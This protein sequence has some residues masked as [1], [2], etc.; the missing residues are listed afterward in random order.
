M[1][2][3]VRDQRH[4]K[5]RATQIFRWLHAVKADRRM[6]ASCVKVAMQLTHKTSE[7]E[8]AKSGTLVS[9]WQ[10][11]LTIAAAIGRG[12][13]T[14]RYAIRRL[15]SCGYVLT[16]HGHGEGQA[17]Q[18]TLILPN[19]QELAAYDGSNTGKVLPVSTDPKR[20]VHAPIPANSEPETGKNLPP[21][22]SSNHLSNYSDDRETEPGAPRLRA[23]A[24][25]APPD[26]GNANGLGPLG[27]D[28]EPE[29]RR[30]LGDRWKWLLGAQV[31]E[32]TD[33]VLV[34]SVPTPS[35]REPILKHCRT[36]LIAVAGISEIRFSTALAVE[37]MQKMGRP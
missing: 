27:A 23:D 22:Y 21:N 1:S 29:L 36:E 3:I 11:E 13:R 35:F 6:N 33:R 9:W 12:E 5:T 16:K 34:L 19:R 10:S 15:E 26:S 18:Y 31:V 28:F 20:Q 7:A 2:R 14:V 37:P 32:R 8:F 24:L 30:L 4:A 17:N 25:G